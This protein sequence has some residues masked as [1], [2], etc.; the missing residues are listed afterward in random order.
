MLSL[1]VLHLWKHRKREKCEEK[2]IAYGNTHSVTMLR[3]SRCGLCLVE[4]RRRRRISGGTGMAHLII[5]QTMIPA[6]EVPWFLSIVQN[7]SLLCW[8]RRAPSP[9]GIRVHAHIL[10]IS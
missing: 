8:M 4:K 1:Y 9:R 7:E 5:T 2:I 6:V 3:T 10:L